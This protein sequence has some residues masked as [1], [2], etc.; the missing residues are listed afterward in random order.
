MTYLLDAD[1]VIDALYGRR[2]A[3]ETLLTLAPEGIAICWV[4]VGEIY[5]G[6]YSRVNSQAHIATFREFLRPLDKLNLNDVIMEQFAE[7]RSS[8]RRQGQIISDFDIL[9]GATALS[10][11]LTV[12]T[13]NTRHLRR[14]PGLKL[15]P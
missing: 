3:A 14:I 1:W 2:Q 9:L 10:H 7:I 13:R 12:L 6:A 5:E 11:D 4:T 8:L 15:Y